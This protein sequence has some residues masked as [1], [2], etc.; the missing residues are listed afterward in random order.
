MDVPSIHVLVDEGLRERWAFVALASACEC[1]PRLLPRVMHVQ[2]HGVGDALRLQHCADR[3]GAKV[4]TLLLRDN[5]ALPR[6]AA[7]PAIVV[8]FLCLK[9]VCA[10]RSFFPFLL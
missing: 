2:W 3:K 7:H 1:C 6:Q 10:Q 8:P 4:A 9:T 5:A